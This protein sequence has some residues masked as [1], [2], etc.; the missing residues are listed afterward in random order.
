[1]PVGFGLAGPQQVEV[2]AVEHVN[3]LGSC[4]GH[5]NPGN[6]AAGGAVIGNNR[7]KGKPQAAS[8]ALKCLVPARKKMAAAG[9]SL[10]NQ[11]LAEGS[12]VCAQACT[13]AKGAGISAAP[14]AL[15]SS[16]FR[17]RGYPRSRACA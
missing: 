16:E 8:D 7:L 15:P 13:H 12:P 17:P 2:R 5:P 10:I 11:C 6:A 4:L 14:K 9:D 1:M 3:R